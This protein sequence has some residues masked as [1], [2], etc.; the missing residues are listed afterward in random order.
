VT[1]DED[2]DNDYDDYKRLITV[3]FFLQN[4]HPYYLGTEN[5]FLEKPGTERRIFFPRQT[6]TDRP[7]AG[8]FEQTERASPLSQYR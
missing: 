3:S 6:N 1:D 2:N 5:S 4:L 8:W 7:I